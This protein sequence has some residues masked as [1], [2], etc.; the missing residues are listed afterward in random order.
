[1]ILRVIGLVNSPDLL[2]ILTGGGPGDATQVLSL[3]AFQTAYKEFNFG[4]ASALSVVMFVI[5][6]IFATAYIRLSRITK[7]DGDD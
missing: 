5:L 6:M 7:G 3:Y 4:Y 1:V 2:L